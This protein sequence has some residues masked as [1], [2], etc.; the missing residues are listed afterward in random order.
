M[1]FW[2]TR[3]LVRLYMSEHHLAI[4]ADERATMA[5]TYLALMERGAVEE[6]D[7]ALILAPLFRPSSDGIVKDDAA[8]DMSPAGLLSKAMNK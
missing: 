4:D 2:A 3:I 1:A 8:P 7:R 6:K 5:L